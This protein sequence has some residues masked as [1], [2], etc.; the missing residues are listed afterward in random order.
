MPGPR[1]DD[2]VA[3]GVELL[4]QR[5]RDAHGV[6]QAA[7]EL[8][9][10]GEHPAVADAAGEVAQLPGRLIDHHGG[11]RVAHIEVAG[12]VLRYCGG[13]NSFVAGVAERALVRIPVHGVRVGVV[14]VQAQAAAAVAREPDHGRLIGGVGSARDLVNLVDLVDNW[15]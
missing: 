7:V 11:G 2:G 15:G 10:A 13:S 9:D 5:A 8:P 14:G 12:S 1:P 4:G 6:G 3:G